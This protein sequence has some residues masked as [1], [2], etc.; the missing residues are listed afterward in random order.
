MIANHEELTDL[1]AAYATD[2]LEAEERR[3]VEVALASDE[4]LR[5]ELDDHHAV[6]ATLAAAVDHNPSTPSNL[7]WERIAGQI[8]GID[9]VTPKLASI[10]DIRS[11]RRVSRITAAVSIAAISL[12]AVLAVTVVRMQQER[13]PDPV[14]VAIQGLLEDPG[15]TLATLS[16]ADGSAAEARIVFGSNG[17]GYVYAD[18]LPTLDSTRTYQLWAIVGDQVISAGV[19][20]PDPDNSP[21]QVVGDIAGFAITEEVAGGVPVSEGET[22]AVWLRNA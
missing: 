21:F 20:G 3:L 9:E 13:D 5:H 18:S 14:A 4:Q 6:L 15:A 8:G 19:L 16:A 22:V 12:A 2:S 1:V 11:Q 17:I 7:V 10:H